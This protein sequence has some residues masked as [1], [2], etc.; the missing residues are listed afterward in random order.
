[1]SFPSPPTT[2]IIQA[3]NQ[4]QG[5]IPTEQGDVEQYFN[6][7]PSSTHHTQRKSP[8]TYKTEFDKKTSTLYLEKFYP[9]KELEKLQPGG[10]MYKYELKPIDEMNVRGGRVI[11]KCLSYTTPTNKPKMR[12]LDGWDGKHDLIMSIQTYPSFLEYLCRN[13]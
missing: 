13:F 8:R 5:K 12:P 4:T 6:T 2:P 7:D 10:A 11:I 9:P 1:M 3:L